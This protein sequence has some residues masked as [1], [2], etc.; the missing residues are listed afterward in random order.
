MVNDNNRTHN[1]K[2]MSFALSQCGIE[3]GQIIA[4]HTKISALN[5]VRDSDQ[6]HNLMHTTLQEEDYLTQDKVHG[7][8][9][10]VD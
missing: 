2:H 10:G 5:D 7:R 8:W 4:H 3:S 6:L 1:N 9:H